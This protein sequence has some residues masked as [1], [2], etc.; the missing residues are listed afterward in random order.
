MTTTRSQHPTPEGE[1]GAVIVEFAAIFVVF[2]MLLWGLI[3][4]GVIFAAQQ[5][6]THAASDA[7]RS[8]VGMYPSED[9][10][11]QMVES[12]LRAQVGEDSW[13]DADGL[14]QADVTFAACDGTPDRECATVVVIYDWDG[15]GIVP[16]MLSVATPDTLS[17]QAVVQWD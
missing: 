17:S 5:T 11:E 7:A 3:T 9:D 12:V 6:I 10:A 15:Y 1:S 13:L 2:A 16:E 14:V 8:V 4:Y